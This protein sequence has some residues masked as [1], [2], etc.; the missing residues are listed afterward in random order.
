MLLEMINVNINAYAN[1]YNCVT[2]NLR[3]FKLSFWMPLIQVPIGQRCSYGN[4]HVH[5]GLKLYIFRLFKLL[6]LEKDKVWTKKHTLI[7]CIFIRYRL[8]FLTF[9]QLDLDPLILIITFFPFSCQKILMSDDVIET[10]LCK[11]SLRKLF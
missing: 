3:A 8:V 10:K 5:L 6:L 11:T 4:Q 1:K 9:V 2:K 7:R